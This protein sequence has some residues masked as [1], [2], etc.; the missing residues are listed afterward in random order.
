RWVGVVEDPGVPI[1]LGGES[2]V[3]GRLAG[4]ALRG[5]RRAPLRRRGEH[6]LDDEGG[7][8]LITKADL[9]EAVD[10]GIGRRYDLGDECTDVV[11]GQIDAREGDP[12]TVSERIAA[13]AEALDDL[14][15]DVG[16]GADAREIAVGR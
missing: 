3:A 5:A 2:D 12:V 13:S 6:P 16:L 9:D 4:P 1:L 7:V 15:G 11:T 14:M 10:V 8:A